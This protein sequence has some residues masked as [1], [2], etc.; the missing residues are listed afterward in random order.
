M[1]IAWQHD[2][3]WRNSRPA[4]ANGCFL[5]KI[6]VL[7]MD[8]EAGNRT[9]RIWQIWARVVLSYASG[10]I[11]VDN[12]PI[13]ETVEIYQQMIPG[14]VAEFD[15]ESVTDKKDLRLWGRKPRDKEKCST[16]DEAM[17]ELVNHKEIAT[18]LVMNC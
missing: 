10:T 7:D 9:P 1:N 11:P 4:L 13:H 5:L 15:D 12:E 6:S 17:M 2:K 18:P 3:P 16:V 8:P 14:V